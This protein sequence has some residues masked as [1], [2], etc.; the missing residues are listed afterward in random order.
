MKIDARR[1]DAV[2]SD[3][4][5]LRAVLFFGEDEGLV[6]ELA[7]RLVRSVAGSLTDPF[8]VVD[9]ERDNLGSL[10]S[11]MASMSLMGGRKVVRLRDATDAATAA[12]LSALEIEGGGLL[13]LEGAGLTN[14][15]KLKTALEKSDHA[16]VYACY[17]MDKPALQQM[18]RAAMA[19]DQ[20]SIDAEV[21][22]W[23]ADHL[24]A[25]RG[26]SHGALGK[27]AL[28]AGPKG[29]V[30]I[31]AAE[32]C[33]GDLSGLSLEDASFAAICGDVAA[34]DRALELAL[35]EGGT[36]VGVLRSV[37]SQVQRVARVIALMQDGAEQGEAMRALR[38][39][40]FFKRETAFRSAL[41]KW[42]TASVAGA[43]ERLFQAEKECKRTGSPAEI[44]CRNAVLAIAGRAAAA[45]RRR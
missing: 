14:K 23:L 35:A 3:P 29:R 4:G 20:I 19:A 27:L 32:L 36:A 22:S 30:D 2:I 15:S 13:V 8:L 38:P 11:E 6:R 26:V 1:L 31:E 7:S 40:V 9:V 43:L 37:A 17:P 18:V 44:I 12:V 41:R 39:P 10:R 33:V 5:R 24:G 42:D 28:Y 45:G 21:V 25:D 16:G 34:A